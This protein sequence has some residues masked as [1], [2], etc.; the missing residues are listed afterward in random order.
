VCACF[1]FKITHS[2]L[3]SAAARLREKN[4]WNFPPI[5]RPP[6]PDSAL[7]HR[8]ILANFID[9]FAL[10]SHKSLEIPET[11]LPSPFGVAG[12]SHQ[13]ILSVEAGPDRQALSGDSIEKPP[14][15]KTR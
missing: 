14:S 15:E 3:I 10:M 5:F 11:V 12:V 6:P 9:S 2:N 8:I 7:I 13:G 4:G 1:S